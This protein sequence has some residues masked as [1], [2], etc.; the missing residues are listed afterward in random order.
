MGRH[1][2]QILTI[3]QKKAIKLA[4][5]TGTV[6]GALALTTF[7]ASAETYTVKPGDTLS[8]IAS[9]YNTT[10]PALVELNHIG[11]VDYLRVNQTI[12]TAQQVKPETAQPQQTDTSQTE[13][14]TATPALVYTVKAGDTLSL[15]ANQHGVTVA[16]IIKNSNIENANLIYV[17]QQLTLK[18]E[19]KAEKPKLPPKPRI[20]PAVTHT[21][22]AG[23]SLWQIANNTKVSIADIANNSHL[24]NANLIYPGQ[25]LIIK[26]AITIYSGGSLSIS[27][28]ELAGQ[29]GISEQSAQNAID[30]ANYLM[31]QEGFTVEG[32]AG[33]LAVAERESG[34]DP[35]AINTSGGVA[36][37]FQWSGWSNNINGN[38]W[39]RASEKTL[40][41]P[42]QLELVS[43]ELNSN[44][45]HVKDLVA[46]AT[47]AKQASL[48]WTVYYEG[49][50]LSDPQT[51]E[52]TLLKNADKWYDLLKDHV[53][54]STTDA[55]AVPFD[56]TQG[57]YSSTG[58]T[59]AAGQCTWYV[60]DIF[61]A[62]MGDYW[63]NAK[64]W[65]QSA[66]REGL[67][68]DANPVA[69]QTIAVFGPGSA[70]A[71]ATYGH[72]AVVIGVL[73]DTVTVKEMNGPAGLWKT[74][75]RVVPKSAATYIHMNY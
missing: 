14:I 60:K 29:A 15:I 23:E 27:A 51:K 53:T 9:K 11:N 8:S 16:D 24:E 1:D 33:A 74:N 47:D 62:R 50:A 48:D 54:D 67:T 10:I 58:N 65:A 61:K 34:F 71:D 66:Q 35:E 63:G 31:G 2:K 64:D 43:T 12:E 28:S 41:M 36:G 73:G 19:V 57:P 32:A 68:V 13:T 25:K 72:V 22:Q 59:Y 55:V 39:D 40:S 70:G 3:K 44:F 4:L 52:A 45:K 75:T 18:P 37:I 26:P 17:G 21:V 20:I 42:V 49:V 46:N 69:N 38:R 5:G 30:I 56:V 6:A 7:T